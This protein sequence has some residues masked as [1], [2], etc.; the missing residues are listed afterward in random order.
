MLA[1][2]LEYLSV[3]NY[4]AGERLSTEKY[5]YVAG[6]VL[7]LITIVLLVIYPTCYGAP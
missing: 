1:K 7:K 5:E 6:Q 2:Q 4:L 3:L